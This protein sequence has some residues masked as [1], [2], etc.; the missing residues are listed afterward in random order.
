MSSATLSIERGAVAE[1]APS[2]EMRSRFASCAF[3]TML[4]LGGSQVLR[5]A[6]NL[7]LTRLLFPGAFGLMALVNVFLMGLA[8]F[9]DVGI[10]PSIIHRKGAPSVAF[11]Q[12]AWTIQIIRSAILFGC[13][14]LLALPLSLF[15][16]ER[17][18][19]A[20]LPV[21]GLTQ[22][23]AGFKSVAVHIC[24]RELQHGKIA[25][26]DLLVALVGITAS[27]VLAVLLKNVWALVLGGLISSCFAVA[28]TFLLPHQIP[29]RLRLEPDAA[30]ELFHFGKWIVLGT[31]LT[32]LAS[33]GD[34]I[35]L[36]K[37]LSL[38]QLGIYTVAFFFAQSVSSMTRGLASRVLFP[39]LAKLRATSSEVQLAEFVR[40]RRLF[41]AA[42]LIPVAVFAFGGDWIIELLYDDR[43]LRAGSLLRVLCFGAAASTLVGLG[44]PVLLSN[45]NSRGRMW[46]S[47]AEACS[48][49]ICISI[50]GILFGFQGFI[51]GYVTAQFLNCISVALLL[52]PYRVASPATDGAFF[53]ALALIAVLSLWLHPFHF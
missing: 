23:V 39:I 25:L 4:N 53:G 14:V 29:I 28:A 43:Y 36:G 47:F 32:Y 48:L 22:L 16:G 6:S 30:R 35:I 51:L 9:S 33:E 21:V 50:G 17:Q 24:A 15:Y 31:A 41:L 26:V 10:G 19:L 12:T 7:V 44:D 46:L 18:L 2:G 34:R 45:G 49:I 1:K 27:I 52:R 42:V 38:E 8:M 13:T 5:L 20:V 3:Y 11:L 37:V 40:Y